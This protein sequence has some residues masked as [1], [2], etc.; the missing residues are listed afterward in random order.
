MNS[1]N[2]MT[3]WIIYSFIVLL[4]FVSFA[5][6]KNIEVYPPVAVAE[7]Y[8]PLGNTTTE[9]LFNASQSHIKGDDTVLFFRWD[10]DGD[11]I[12][13]NSYSKS[14]KAYH[15]YYKL[16]EYYPILMVQ[17][18]SGLSDTL[19]FDKIEVKQGF[20]PPHPSFSVFPKYGNIIT[21]F[22]FDAS[23]SY[24]DE[25][26]LSNLKYR[27]DWE[28]DDI[29][30]TKYLSKP[31][32]THRFAD[33]GLFNVTLE[34]TDKKGFSSFVHNEVLVDLHSP[35]LIVDFKILPDSGSTDDEFIFDATASEDIKNTNNKLSYR[36]R[37]TG[38]NNNNLYELFVTEFL[39][40]PVFT[41]QFYATEFGKKKMYLYVKDEDGLVNT[42]MK[43]FEVHY[44]NLPPTSNFT[45][46]PIRG[47]VNTD[48]YFRSVYYAS[49][50]DEFSHKLKVRWDF[51]NDGEWDTDV[52]RDNRMIFH[53]YSNPGIYD[54]AC[55]VMD[56]RGLTDIL[57]QKVYVSNGTNET[58][59]VEHQ[60]PPYDKT[61]WKYYGT[62]KIGNQ[63]WT[64]E[65]MNYPDL[66][67]YPQLSDC[68]D[69][70]K[71]NCEVFGG[72]YSLTDLFKVAQ[73]DGK[74]QPMPICPTGWH[75]PSDSE[76][77]TLISYYGGSLKA[78][79][80]LKPG[81][82]SDF[83][84]LMAGER[85]PFNP[86]NMYREVFLG[87]GSYSVFWTSTFIGGQ[88]T[89][90]WRFNDGTNSLDIFSISPSYRFSLRCIKD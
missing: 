76:W 62:I 55:E 32:I 15:R 22:Y 86:N 5:C 56:S 46:I 8:P 48:F 58:S 66:E 30:D 16:G 82:S 77:F 90:V 13:D 6:E 50:P 43:E 70:L 11:N 31:I 54:V 61:K 37:L 59:Y 89:R 64:S 9:F 53:Q 83:N 18:N 12:W 75:I 71:I 80:E 79:K 17:N 63:W 73:G 38:V 24:D 25:D 29:W 26:S 7:V 69:D 40:N 52:S 1:L 2:F 47:N 67:E 14:P 60:I 45:I 74:I 81:G 20:S 33:D 39:E 27:W 21:D 72:L 28:A 85:I 65:N 35:S 88:N 19:L 87:L 49:D 84:I 23:L 36:W 34:V 3:K 51:E 10:W 68:Y 4:A 42:C 44:S 41:Y 78:V 57:I